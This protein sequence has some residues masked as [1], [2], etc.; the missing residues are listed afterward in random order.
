MNFNLV[1]PCKLCPYRKDCPPGWLGQDRAQELADGVIMGDQS[2]PCHETVNYDDWEDEDEQY[3][4]NGKERF[5]AGALILESKCNRGG[6][7]TIRIARMT[8]MFSYDQL[9]NVELIFDSTKDF[10]K[11]H[12]ENIRPSRRT[13]TKK[14]E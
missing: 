3:Q 2:F 7:L 11:H 13:S 14:P 4:Y 6:N 8:K 5:C 1:R 9:K 12:S 10:I